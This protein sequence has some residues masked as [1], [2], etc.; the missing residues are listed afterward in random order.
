M[1]TSLLVDRWLRRFWAGMYDYAAEEQGDP[2]PV[3]GKGSVVVL[4]GGAEESLRFVPIGGA[5]DG[6]V[7]TVDSGAVNDVSWSTPSDVV[8][9]GYPPPPRVAYTNQAVCWEATG[10]QAHATSGISSNTIEYGPHYELDD[11][12]VYSGIQWEH[13]NT[14]TGGAQALVALYAVDAS[15]KPGALIWYSAATAVSSAAVETTTFASGTW[16]SLGTASYKSGNNLVLARGAKVWKAIVRNATGAPNFRTLQAAATRPTGMS[17][18][19]LAANTGFTEAFT[20]AS[21]PP[22]PATPVTATGA[23]VVTQLVWV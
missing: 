1:P 21:P 23:R 5:S 22:D 20:F 17:T 7:L 9:A 18:A 11:A 12:A 4:G 3:L 6:D 2:T 15:D 10:A 19:S 8:D 16:T 14:T 13:T